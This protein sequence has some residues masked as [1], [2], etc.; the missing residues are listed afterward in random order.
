MKNIIFIVL[1]TVLLLG[2]LN[3]EGLAARFSTS[4]A[5]YLPEY[6]KYDY[7]SPVYGF[8]IQADIF[9]L[10]QNYGFGGEVFL[11][12][13]SYHQYFKDLNYYELYL[14]NFSG[15]IEEESK[16]IFGFFAGAR[17]TDIYFEDR[18]LAHNVDLMFTRPVIGVKFIS[19]N[20]GGILRWT[21]TENDRSKYEYEL[22]FRNEAGFIFQFGGSLK[23]PVK[24][25]KSDFHL[26]IGYEFFL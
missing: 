14:H 1:L 8:D 10:Y 24:G 25:V 23:G 6:P 4:T 9:N 26:S 21:Q 17:R 16:F 7:N 11:Q 13:S 12:F 2:N 22:K 18:D 15:Q 19:N 3:A 20:W 5:A